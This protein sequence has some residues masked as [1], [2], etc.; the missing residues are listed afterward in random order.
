MQEKTNQFLEKLNDWL[1]KA[2]EITLKLSQRLF[3][4]LQRLWAW[5]QSLDLP[6]IPLSPLQWTL[7]FYVIFAGFFLWATPIFEASDELWHFGMVEY[8]TEHAQ[9]PIQDPDHPDTL[10]R[11]EGSQPPLYYALASAVISPIDISDAPDFRILNP[12]ANTGRPAAYGNKN[13]VLH[14]TQ[15]PVL[16]GTV[17]AVYVLR[18]FSILMGFVTVWAVFQSAKLLATHRPVVAILAA[19]ITAFNPMFLFISASVNNDNLVIMLNS[20]V[21]WFG[22]L[23]LRDGFDTRRSLALAAL[24]A[25]ATLTKLSAL[26]LVPVIAFAA[27]WLALRDKNW[28]GL[29]ILG[30][31]MLF[32]WLL[33]AGWWYYRNIM[34]YGELFGTQMMV[35][36]AGARPEVLDLGK[37]MGMLLAEFEGFRMSYWGIFGGFNI[38]TT[39]LFY[40]LLDFIVFV[41]IFGVIFLVAQL[42][43]I[44]DFSYARRELSLMLFLLGVVLIGGLALISWTAQTFASQ[45]RLM[46]PFIA[47]V[48]PLLAVGLVELIWWMLFLLSPPDRSFVRAGD[49]VPDEILRQALAYPMR[50]LGLFALILPFLAIAPNYSAPAPLDTIPTRD[51]FVTVY[52]DYGAIELIGYEHVD[53]RYLPGERVEL[54]FY[55]RVKEQSTEDYSLALTLLSPYGDRL[56][57]V[58]TYPGA[59]ALRTSTWEVG[60]IYADTYEVPLLRAI[61]AR[62]PFRVK[63]DWYDEAPSETLDIVNR[64][65]VDLPVVLL[66]VGA[67]VQPNYSL[68]LTRFESLETVDRFE[69]EFGASIRLTS[70]KVLPPFT[71]EIE[72]EAINSMDLDYTAFVHVLNAEGEL[73]GQAD[74]FPEL[75][76]HY[77]YPPERYVTQHPIRFLADQLEPGT[78]TVL[79]GWYEN[80]G[81]DYP[82][83]QIY[84]MDKEKQRDNFELFQ[85]PMNEFGLPLIPEFT[86]NEAEATDDEFLPEA[87]I[88]P[89]EE[90]TGFV[91][92]ITVEVRESATPE[93]TG[94]ITENAPNPNATQAPSE[95]TAE[96]TE[97]ALETEASSTVEPESTAS[98]DAETEITPE[99]TPEAEATLETD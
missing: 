87:P 84:E 25:C 32:F 39:V 52:A 95:M 69:R 92:M 38:Q 13:L 91:P 64:D 68:S 29:V 89:L 42:V 37:L 90:S 75:P 82:R 50:F 62:Y 3:V 22:L 4:L 48:S 59:G 7:L 14:S 57:G 93:A 30:S 41:A 17:L 66:D 40:A 11:Q 36:I 10:Y 6:E 58:D 12:H 19:A 53:R 67:V 79:V 44:R 35:Q 1:F 24:L 61:S 15:A 94:E 23:T 99:A 71:V 81:E 16:Q 5:Y 70:F 34:L 76:T 45:G 85:F 2:A 20:L 80:N 33:I 51:N 74:T 73:V 28:K 27:I 47:A 21:I 26:A 60:K 88:I 97:S 77:W 65:G 54:T 83:L 56:G 8:I 63:V 46:F 96:A 55:W 18:V 31:A 86:E 43:S 9:L 78:Y 98:S 49:A 72:W